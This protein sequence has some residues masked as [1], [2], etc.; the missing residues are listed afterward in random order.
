MVGSVTS[1]NPL[2]HSGLG[3]SVD[4]MY[5]MASQS[6]TLLSDFQS[7]PSFTWTSSSKQLTQMC[8]SI[9]TLQESRVNVASN[10]G[11]REPCFATTAL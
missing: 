10:L 6:W 2:Q 7:L 1:S 11:K 4:C 8:T 9:P 3:N 5:S